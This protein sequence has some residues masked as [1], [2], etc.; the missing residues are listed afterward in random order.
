MLFNINL[1]YMISHYIIIIL[2]NIINMLNFFKK[3]IT[4]KNLTSTPTF[5]AFFFLTYQ[6]SDLIERILL[7]LLN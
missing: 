6:H 1:Q 3:Q 4:E 5:L 7:N 2:Y